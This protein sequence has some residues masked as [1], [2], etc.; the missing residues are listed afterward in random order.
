MKLRKISFEC[1]DEDTK[2]LFLKLQQPPG[3]Y[4][5]D[6]D[7]NDDD[8]DDDWS[9]IINMNAT[10]PPVLIYSPNY[11]NGTYNNY[12]HCAVVIRSGAEPLLLSLHYL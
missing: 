1:H 6:V 12:Q 9:N 5:C 4:F 8:D 2:Y 11:G 10:S 7:D 3:Y